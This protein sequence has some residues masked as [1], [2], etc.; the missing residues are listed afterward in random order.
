MEV[1]ISRRQ[2][3]LLSLLLL[4]CGGGVVC[5]GTGIGVCVSVQYW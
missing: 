1:G 4:L 5:C 3:L 2:L